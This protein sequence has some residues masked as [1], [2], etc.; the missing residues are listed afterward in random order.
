ME[1]RPP[2]STGFS[3]GMRARN[4]NLTCS[5]A[6]LLCFKPRFLFFAFPTCKVQKT[7]NVF[8]VPKKRSISMQSMEHVMFISTR[9]IF[10]L[11]WQAESC[12]PLRGG[13]ADY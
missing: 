6:D 1:E 12:P 9:N 8:V 2:W 5:I 4:S 10:V 11:G 7:Q 3:K 13:Y